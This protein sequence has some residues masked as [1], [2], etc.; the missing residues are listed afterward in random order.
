MSQATDPQIRALQSS[1]TCRGSSLTHKLFSLTLLQ[2]FH[3]HSTTGSTSLMVPSPWY[4]CHS[5]T[6]HISLCL[7]SIDSDVCRLTCSCIQCQRAKIQRHSMARLFSF[8]TPDARFD[9]VHIDI[10]RPLPPSQGFMYLLTCVDCYTRW[11][12]AVPLTSITTKIVS[13]AFISG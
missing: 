7:A 8:P 10:V 1:L 5:K 6:D 9:V 4:L 11:P 12:E 3:W 2:H 13:Q